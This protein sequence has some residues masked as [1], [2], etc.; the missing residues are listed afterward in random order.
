[1]GEEGSRR[2]IQEGLDRA[3]VGDGDSFGRDVYRCSRA[4]VGLELVF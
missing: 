4:Q 1:M 3:A 2:G